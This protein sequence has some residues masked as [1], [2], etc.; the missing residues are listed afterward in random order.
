MTGVASVYGQALY[1]LACDEGLSDGILGEMKVLSDAF[2][3]NAGFIRLVS[4]P[5][6]SKA[7]RLNIIHES[8]AGKVNAYVLNFMKILTEKGY[9]RYFCDC[10]EV[11]REKYN[12]DHGILAVKAV[13][14]HPMTEDQLAR[15]SAKLEKITGKKIELKNAIDLSCIGGVR[16]DYDGK[17]VEDTVANRLASIGALLK[18]TVL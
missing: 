10:Y 8:F 17:R 4:S 16:L 12:A 5:S 7:E 14:A 11:Y 3:Q 18:N 6:L 1:D 9:M 2:G 15:L 13:T